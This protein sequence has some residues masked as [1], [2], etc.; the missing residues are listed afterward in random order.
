MSAI[1]TKVVAATAGSGAGAVLG[2]FGLWLLGVSVWG[3][4]GD[5]ADVADAVAA[6]PTPVAG[7]VLLVISALGAAV[8]GYIAPH[9]HSSTPLLGVPPDEPGEH[10]APEVAP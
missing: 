4:S 1:E 2:T 10:A 5:A 7:L 3:A 6:V 8:A 9:T